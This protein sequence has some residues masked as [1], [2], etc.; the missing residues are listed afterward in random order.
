[1]AY[2]GAGIIISRAQFLAMDAIYE[3]CVDELWETFGGDGIYTRWCE[4]MIADD[5]V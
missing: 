2:G 1:M 4:A 3:E 5:S